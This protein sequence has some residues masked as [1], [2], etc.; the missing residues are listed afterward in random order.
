MMSP[1]FAALGDPSGTTP[2]EGSLF[3]AS[4]KLTPETPETSHAKSVFAFSTGVDAAGISMDSDAL[5]VIG[6]VNL[7]RYA[8]ELRFTCATFNWSKLADKTCSESKTSS[9]LFGS[10]GEKVPTF[11]PLGGRSADKL[12]PFLTSSSTGRGADRGIGAGEWSRILR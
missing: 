11:N 1:I 3:R 5:S 8:T 2:V 9:G 7:N 12:L 4:V 6:T 10:F